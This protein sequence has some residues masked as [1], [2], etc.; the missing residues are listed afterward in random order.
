MGRSDVETVRVAGHI[1]KWQGALVG[2][3]IAALRE[4]IIASRDYLF[5]A[6]GVAVPLFD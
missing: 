2:Q 3:N 1:K 5:E 6:A 4:Q